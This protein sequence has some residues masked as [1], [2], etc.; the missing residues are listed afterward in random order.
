MLA[1]LYSSILC[2]NVS[3]KSHVHI[4][5]NMRSKV[6]VFGI[7]IIP[8]RQHHGAMGSVVDSQL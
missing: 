1:Q 4:T 5:C 6:I 2:I 7:F 8:N 3:E